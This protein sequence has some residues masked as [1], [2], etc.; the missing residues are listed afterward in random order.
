MSTS[1][2]PGH[3]QALLGPQ[4]LSGLRIAGAAVWPI[5]NGAPPPPP[6]L[7]PLRSCQPGAIW[8]LPRSASSAQR[9]VQRGGEQNIWAGNGGGAFQRLTLLLLEALEGGCLGFADLCTSGR[10]SPVRSGGLC[11]ARQFA[12]PTVH[13]VGSQKPRTQRTLLCKGPP[14]GGNPEKQTPCVCAHAQVSVAAMVR[15][16]IIDEV[17]LLNDERGPVIETLVA[18]TTRQVGAAHNAST[19]ASTQASKEASKQARRA[20]G[21]VPGP[22]WNV[23]AGCSGSRRCV[24]GFCM[25]ESCIPGYE[26]LQAA[27]R[28]GSAGMWRGP[29]VC[30]RAGRVTGQAGAPRWCSLHYITLHY[31][32]YNVHG[33][34][35][36]AA[37][38]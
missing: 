8:R 12:E 23:D 21:C 26:R 2:P 29:G 6:P 37:R 27:G 16:L 9:A 14:G 10:A 15:L 4:S 28:L 17:H 11:G 31:K 7:A 5:S 22:L 24:R 13:S 34:R 20:G 25:E 32:L 1:A 30:S 35:W 19:Q 33:C 38:A 36:R 3:F 18:R